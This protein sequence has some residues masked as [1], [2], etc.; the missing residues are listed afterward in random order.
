MAKTIS[1]IAKEIGV[2]RQAVWYKTKNEQFADEIKK[3]SKKIGKKLCIDE[4]GEK[5]IKNAFTQDVDDNNI[6]YVINDN[7]V[8]LNRVKN[9]NNN[10]NSTDKQII[11]VLTSQLS[12]LNKHN[13]DL[14]KEINELS[15][16]LSKEREHAREL[17]DKLAD[18][19]ANA[20][21]LHAGDIVV[22][23]LDVKENYNQQKK[24]SIFDIL[25]RRKKCKQKD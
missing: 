21:K 25:F 4:E 11:D 23:R 1:Q 5:I 13:N 20:Q 17:A 2:S 12:I 24:N 10:V 15:K 22:P 16:E 3:H 6:N 14:T 19:A 9:D 7:D 8:K 18:L